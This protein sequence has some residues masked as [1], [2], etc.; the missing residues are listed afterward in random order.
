MSPWVLLPSG[1][2]LGRGRGAA[3]VRLR[4]PPRLLFVL[5]AVDGQLLLLSS[6]HYSEEYTSSP[7]CVHLFID[8]PVFV[9]FL[10]FRTY[11]DFVLN[12]AGLCKQL[13][14][15]FQDEFENDSDKSC[16]EVHVFST[17]KLQ[18]IA[19]DVCEWANAALVTDSRILVRQAECV[20]GSLA[21]HDVDTCSFL[22]MTL[23]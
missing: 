14:P 7:P 17:E 22:Y 5:R 3:Q 20:T 16:V 12:I 10:H 18:N 11:L 9:Y 23:C 8:F 2:R 1:R 21:P 6:F 15:R 13:P 4:H 19:S